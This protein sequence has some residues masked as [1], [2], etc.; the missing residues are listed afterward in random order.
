MT[1]LKGIAVLLFTAALAITTGLSLIDKVAE[2]KVESKVIIDGHGEI[3]TQSE[4]AA[5]QHGSYRQPNSVESV[6][7]GVKLS[8]GNGAVFYLGKIDLNSSK[9][10]GDANALS[11]TDNESFFNFVY[12]PTNANNFN[13]SNKG[14]LLQFTIKLSNNDDYFEI[15]VTANVSNTDYYLN[16]TTKGK[17][18][19][20]FG[21]YRSGDNYGF[22]TEVNCKKNV[23]KSEDC[24]K[25]GLGNQDRSI[26]TKGNGA[27]SIPFYYDND[28][29]ALYTPLT[30]TT[31]TSLKES[32]LIRDFDDEGTTY[33][34]GE[35]WQGFTAENGKKPVDVTVT[36]NDVVNVE[37]TAIVVT[38]LGSNYLTK[39]T[40]APKTETTLNAAVVNGNY[41]LM[42]GG[43]T[44][45]DSNLPLQVGDVIKLTPTTES[46]TNVTL[47]DVRKLS[48]NGE[49][50]QEKL[51]KTQTLS[52][53]YYSYTI[54]ENDLKQSTLNLSV[55]FDRLCDVTV[56]DEASTPNKVTYNEWLTDGKF[57]FT[58]ETA[59]PNKLNVNPV[60]GKALLCYARL[61]LAEKDDDGKFKLKRNDF[62]V[63]SLSE[64]LTYK[65]SDEISLAAANKQP[66]NELKTAF[67][68]VPQ[69]QFK[70]VYCS[71][72]NGYEI[73]L[74]S[75]KLNDYSGLRFT[76]NFNKDDL[77][78]YIRYIPDVK[79]DN[80]FGDIHNYIT[81]MHQIN[82]A[83]N[84]TNGDYDVNSIT[85]NDWS[86]NGWAPD[87]LNV[88]NGLNLVNGTNATASELLNKY[89]YAH[90]II[91]DGEPLWNL[92]ASS[93]YYYAVTLVNITKASVNNK[94]V[95]MPC[96]T[97]KYISGSQTVMLLN[98]TVTNLKTLATDKFHKHVSN[99]FNSGY[100]YLFCDQNNVDYYSNYTMT[101]VQWLVNLTNL[102][103][104]F[105]HKKTT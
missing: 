12:Q 28:E 43:Q 22:S 40:T 74:T 90:Q 63:P 56:Y 72:Y 35:K 15:K 92:D 53:V 19:S 31:N 59:S 70:A 45:T 102:N 16:I 93:K 69:M 44:I 24:E 20:E 94:Y 89:S 65:F 50:I 38:K 97:L 37:A 86:K 23:I 84:V 41:S 80:P 95:F 1:K 47:S 88:Y 32:Y 100:K 77:N 105:Y 73:K 81:T 67:A 26:S 30:G 25:L 21:T 66:N 75:G 2:A 4:G 52:E 98:A 18:Q 55:T 51:T 61:D 7:T 33:N 58:N 6:H 64:G 3:I 82:S 54:T 42:R 78:E 17:S 60:N 71:V 46:L 27:V 68:L 91:L 57:N 14:E 36:F 104:T 96:V 62:N 11:G 9:W 8:G 101:D 49:N 39:E 103:L 34:N 87:D 76:V 83:N 13:A 79:N 29:N 5:V 48:V 10:D 85:V 99:D